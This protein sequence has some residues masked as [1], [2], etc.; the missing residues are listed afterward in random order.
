MARANNE[1]NLTQSVLKALDVLECL[2]ASRQPLS[3]QEI[4]Q[5]CSFSRPTAYRLLKTLAKRGFVSTAEDSAQYHIGARVLDLSKNFL[6]RLDLTELAKSDMLELSR[7]S[8]E[9]VHL[10]VLDDTEMLYIGKVDGSW[11]VR[12]HCTIGTRNP[13]YCTSLGKAVLAYLPPEKRTALL[14]RITFEPRT[15]NTITDRA[16]LADHLQR[17]RSQGFAVDDMEIEE[18]VRCLGAPIFDHVGC[19]IA[20]I[21]I[22]GPA[23]RLP[24]DRLEALAGLVR[25]AGLAISYKLGYAPE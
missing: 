14:D 1:A 23:Y 5:L 3:V 4:A 20:A 11:S 15:P 21:S 6:E 19:A 8:K 10:A 18:G 7:A 25:E 2:A 13:L 22:S 24:D 9:T 12:M 16:V 17:V